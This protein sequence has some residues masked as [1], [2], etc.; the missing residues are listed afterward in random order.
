MLLADEIVWSGLVK[1]R[2]LAMAPTSRSPLVHAATHGWGGRAPA[3]LAATRDG[4]RRRRGPRP[5]TV[6]DYYRLAAF[7]HGD[8]GVGRPQVDADYFRHVRQS[9]VRSLRRSGAWPLLTG[10]CRRPH[11][12]TSDL[13]LR[14]SDQL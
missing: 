10:R 12:P 1:A 4:D 3:P 5:S 2:C 8:T 11:P 14:T 13:G 6:G 9:E 7:E